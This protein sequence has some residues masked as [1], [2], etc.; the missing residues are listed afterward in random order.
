[1][2]EQAQNIK[3][4][5][6]CYCKSFDFKSYLNTVVKILTKPA[7]GWETVKATP[8]TT[9]AVYLKY[10]IPSVLLSVIVHTLVHIIFPQEV[11]T[12][13]GT[14][15]F[16]L[17]N[18]IGIDLMML[19][20]VAVSAYIL[21]F[22]AKVKFFEANVTEEAAFK[23]VGIGSAIGA[24]L[25]VVYAITFSVVGWLGGLIGLAGCIYSIYIFFV[26]LGVLTEI[27]NKIPYLISAMI[28]SIIAFFIL[29]IP[30]SMLFPKTTTFSASKGVEDAMKDL[31]KFEQNGNQVMK[32]L[33]NR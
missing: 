9:K 32:G 24:V 33:T 17:G 22:L 10:V 21:F 8:L 12:Y 25:G 6:L 14:V 28:V 16:S 4:N 3:D 31:E 1:M 7:E 20:T 26:G 13:F 11:K 27:K 23:L 30:V 2:N 18:K 19:A 29:S 15:K 5:V